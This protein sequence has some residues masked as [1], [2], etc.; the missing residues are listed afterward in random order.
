MDQR[1]INLYDDFTHRLLARRDF[2]ERLTMLVGSAAAAGAALSFLESNYARAEIVPEADPRITTSAFEAGSPAVRGYLAKPRDTKPESATPVV[3][4]VHQNRG[5]NP[6]IRDI[7][8]RLAIE[9][10]VGMAPDLLTQEGGTPADEEKARDMIAKVVPGDAAGTLAALVASLAGGERPVKVGVIGFC[11]G[12]GVANILATRAPGL[13]A[14]VIYYGLAPASADVARIK[15]P[16]MLHYAGLDTR[17][18]ATM[19]GYEAALKAAGIKYQS[20]VYEGVNHAFSDDTGAER[21]NAEAA[22]LAW[23][24]SIAFLRDSLKA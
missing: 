2:L 8:R 23:S 10:F 20:F 13:G 19:P 12:G 9:G 16:L 5:L 22:N 14:A 1:I 18:N 6:H 11:W 21:Y 7:A 3:L 15:A 24:R 4:V 17:T